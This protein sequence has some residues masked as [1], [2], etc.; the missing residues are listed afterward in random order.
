MNRDKVRARII[1]G[2]VIGFVFAIALSWWNEYYDFK[3]AKYVHDFNWLS[4][5]LETV[6]IIGLASLTIYNTVWSFRHM[7]Y[8]EGFLA[9][10][11]SCKKIRVNENWIPFEKFISTHSE[12]EF[13]HSICPTCYE[14]HYGEF[15]A[16]NP[17]KPQ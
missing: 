1:I 15:L 17:K 13:T 3:L 11:S 12:A 2:V 5:G 4:P 10:C 8:L 7:K 9:V 14:K 6:L 16:N